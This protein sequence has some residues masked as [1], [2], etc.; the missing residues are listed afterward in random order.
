M[1]PTLYI[2]AGLIGSGKSTW[3]RNKVREDGQAVVISRDALRTM[4]YGEYRYDVDQEDFVR[5]LARGF[6]KTALFYGY[7]VVVDETNLTEKKRRWWMRLLEPL[8][9]SAVVAVH[10]TSTQGNVDRRMADDP[11][12]YSRE[13][14]QQV[15]DGMLKVYEPVTEDEGFDEIVEVAI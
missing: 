9:P 12:G 11:R 5:E 2:C 3:A 4:I 6:V 14:W 8:S 7:D 13:K 1:M 15:Y 10:C